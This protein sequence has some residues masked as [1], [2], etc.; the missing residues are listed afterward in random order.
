VSARELHTA[1]NTSSESLQTMELKCK[2]LV[3]D[4]VTAFGVRNTARRDLQYTTNLAYEAMAS[5]LYAADVVEDPNKTRK[6]KASAL[7]A[8]GS[9][10]DAGADRIQVLIQRQARFAYF[11][12][13]LIGAAATL[14]AIVGTG[15]LVAHNWSN[16]IDTSA[17]MVATLLGMFGALTSVFQRITTGKLLLDFTAPRYQL[18]LL[19][20]VRPFIGALFGCVA[21]FAVVAGLLTSGQSASNSARTISLGFFAVVGFAAGFSERFATDM[22]ERAGQLLVNPSGGADVQPAGGSVGSR[23]RLSGGSALTRSADLEARRLS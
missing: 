20:S 3:N 15:F 9:A 11:T 4:S 7:V 5:V 18:R 6:E 23:E 22:L 2:A 19:G 16:H 21:Y 14:A 1:L 10:V 8:A 17:L 13:A 12:W